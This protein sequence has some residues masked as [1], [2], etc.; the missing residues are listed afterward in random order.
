MKLV[1]NMPQAS[2]VDV[3]KKHLK[4]ISRRGNL[5]SDTSDFPHFSGVEISGMEKVTQ[6]PNEVHIVRTE[7]RYILVL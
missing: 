4:F 7:L 6:L 3:K 5:K 1:P 2:Q